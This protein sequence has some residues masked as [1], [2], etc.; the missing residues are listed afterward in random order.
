MSAGAAACPSA[1]EAPSSVQK[2]PSTVAAATAIVA[3][4]PGISSMMPSEICLVTEEPHPDTGSSQQEQC[5]HNQ[6]LNKHQQEHITAQQEQINQQLQQLK[7]QQQQLQQQQ[8]Q[9]E[10]QSI[11]S[12][13]TV[14][15]PTVPVRPEML[16]P[17]AQP[18]PPNAK[19]AAF[20]ECIKEIPGNTL[21]PALAVNVTDAA[22][23]RNIK[24]DN[25]T[26]V[27]H[28]SQVVLQK[29]IADV[30]KLLCNHAAAAIV[31]AVE[32][33]FKAMQ[34]Q[35]VWIALFTSTYH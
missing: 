34:G 27:E 19:I 10:Q 13:T 25:T 31:D 17:M 29:E 20:Q 26:S 1:S 5:L 16:L 30:A 4:A 23:T 18:L 12:P 3:A 14:M 21:A 32:T 11:P 9:L 22:R 28:D 15:S 6:L 8:L 33:Q 2:E 7:Q 24:S 35:E